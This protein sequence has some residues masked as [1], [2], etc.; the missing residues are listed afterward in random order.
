MRAVH[1]PVPGRREAAPALE[2]DPPNPING[3]PGCHRFHPR[4]PI[5]PMPICKE[6]YPEPRLVSGNRAV[7]CH[8]LRGAERGLRDAE[9]LL[10]EPRPVAGQSHSLS[11]PV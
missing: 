9:S 10:A 11:T 7:A 3:P 2:G 1:K 5:S 6:Q 4:C 8:L